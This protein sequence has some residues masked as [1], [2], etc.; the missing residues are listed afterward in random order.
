MK[1]KLFW[2]LKPVFILLGC[3]F[4]WR[5]YTTESLLGFGSGVWLVAFEL[6]NILGYLNGSK[7]KE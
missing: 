2:A 7:S 3:F 6:G 4:A 1:K 5:G